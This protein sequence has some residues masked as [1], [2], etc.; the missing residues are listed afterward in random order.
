MLKTYFQTS[1]VVFYCEPRGRGATYA[2]AYGAYVGGAEGIWHLYV[3]ETALV[4]SFATSPSERARVRKHIE[5]VKDLKKE[6]PLPD[7]RGILL[8]YDPS[9]SWH[10]HWVKLLKRFRHRR[11]STYPARQPFPWEVVEEL[12]NRIPATHIKD[13]T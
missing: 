9:Y 3:G 2:R 7:D 4:L 8:T 12:H 5:Y 6:V 11:L 10:Y 13:F 1:C